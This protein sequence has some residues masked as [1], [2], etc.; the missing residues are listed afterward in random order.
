MSVIF[1]FDRSCAHDWVHRLLPILEVALGK[2]QALPERKI[3]SIEEF[4]SKFA[5]VEQLIIDGTERPVQR[6]KDAEQQQE[7]YSG[8][9]NGILVNTLLAVP[10]TNASFCSANLEQAKCI[11]RSNWTQRIG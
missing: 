10:V 11:T 7:H 3:N 6:P 1:G 9:K 2:K 5:D 8:K 4:I